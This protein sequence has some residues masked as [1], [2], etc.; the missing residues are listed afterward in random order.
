[1]RRKT[2][3]TLVELLV[4]IG[5]IALLISMLLPALNAARKA[6]RQIACGSDLRQI[7]QAILMYAG[8]N[9][10][11]LPGP[12]YS[13]M[14]IPQGFP[15][16]TYPDGS[17]TGYASYSLAGA[18]IGASHMMPQGAYPVFS[19]PEVPY[20]DVV[21]ASIQRYVNTSLSRI[22]GGAIPTS[23][24]S[25]YLPSDAGFDSNVLMPF[26]M[27]AIPPVMPRKLS[28]LGQF[29]VSPSNIWLVRDSQ[30]WHGRYTG[31]KGT[32]NAVVVPLGTIANVL[33]ADGHVEAW[34]E[35]N[36][37]DWWNRSR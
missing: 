18:L 16:G 28:R 7:G 25:S 20:P 36:G 31:A 29:G 9:R 4:V 15:G 27:A 6:A 26:G 13:A 32:V 21:P 17:S 3:F 34:N 30:P 35:G 11:Y 33:C 19:C 24:M 8:A 23:P 2:G 12:S 37:Y 1:M 5:I 10:D 14:G 22:D